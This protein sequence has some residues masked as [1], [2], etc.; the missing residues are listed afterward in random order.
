MVL[1][2]L[3][4]LEKGYS[5][6]EINVETHNY[7]I[8]PTTKDIWSMERRGYFFPEASFMQGK[9]W[10]KNKSSEI[11]F[12]EDPGNARAALQTPLLLIN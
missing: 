8:F 5:S 2:L 11:T 3:A 1:V 4:I 6:S 10:G 9:K 12:S 7:Y